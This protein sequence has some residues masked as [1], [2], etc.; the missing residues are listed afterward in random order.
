M[1]WISSTSRVPFV[2]TSAVRAPFDSRMAFVA[3]VVP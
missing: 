3:T 1:R 2:A